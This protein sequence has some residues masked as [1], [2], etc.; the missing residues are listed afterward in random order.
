MHGGHFFGH[1]GDVRG[2]GWERFGNNLE[3]HWE[4][5]GNTL[6][7]QW[8]HFGN[9][10]RTRWK[11]FGNVGAI[12]LLSNHHLHYFFSYLLFYIKNIRAYY[13]QI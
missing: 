5:L 13:I 9:E 6:R 10:L 4:H 11:R 8:E 2:T 3:T 1:S 12:G 7:M